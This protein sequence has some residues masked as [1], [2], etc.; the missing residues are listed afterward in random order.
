[1]H[2]ADGG[3]YLPELDTL[4]AAA[5]L[6]VMG[7]HF[8]GGAEVL[9]A[10]TV[11]AVRFFFCLSGF[12]LTRLLLGDAAA[13]ARGEIGAG[14]AIA[15]FYARRALR[16]FPAYYLAL[17]LLWLGDAAMVR[18]DLAWHL[19]Y[20]FNVRMAT[21]DAWSG[22]TSHFWSLCVEE[23][24][25]LVWPLVVLGLS[26]TSLRTCLWACIAAGPAWRWAMAMAG[27][28]IAAI[29]LLPGA[30]DAL[31]AGALLALEAPSPAR[32]ARAGAAG[33]AIAL[34]AWLLCA[35][36][37]AGPAARAAFEPLAIT[38]AL[39]PLLAFAAASPA[40]AAAAA[41]R[42]APARALGRV[43]YGAYLYHNLIPVT[44]AGALVASLPPPARVTAFAAATFAC[45][46]VSWHLLE[47]P[48]LSLKALLAPRGGA[49]RAA[50]AEGLA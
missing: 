37:G 17:L 15:S 12:L 13:V 1:M 20:T 8:S 2:A 35:A 27:R 41:L 39:V 34:A 47:R 14:T 48:V 50:A 28:D 40:G 32:A 33:G 3:R 36:A 9:A 25:Y 46:A 26:R 49:P 29:V 16:I 7:W 42:W 30:L 31:A 5:V 18:R 23:Q 24:F 44:A 4:R 22:A 38:G 10:P 45:A 43:S 11:A 21:T 19:T 6:V